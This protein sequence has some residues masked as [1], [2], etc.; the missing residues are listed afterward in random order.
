MSWL[1]RSWGTLVHKRATNEHRLTRLTMARTWGKPPPSRLQYI[2]YLATRP[3]PKCHFVPGL[4]SGNL[5]I[6]KIRTLKTLEAHNFACKPPIEMRSKAKLYPLLRV[7]PTICC[8][9]PACK[10]IGAII[11]F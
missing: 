3:T 11:D 5:E 9:S 1:V 6:P 4:P 7:F 2:L 10:E 8:T